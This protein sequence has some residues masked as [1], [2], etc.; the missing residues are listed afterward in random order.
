MKSGQQ[1]KPAALK[2]VNGNPGGRPIQEEV[3][4]PVAEI[5]RPAFVKGK[6][7]RI[8]KQYAPSLEA[9]G[10]LTVWDVDM[11]GAWCCLMAEFQRDPEKFTSAKL[12]Q[13]RLFAECFCLVPPGRARFTPRTN[14]KEDEDSRF[15]G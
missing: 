6:A 7:A 1:P 10:V 12:T 2:L 15:F 11:F 5:K 13:M 3:K 4:P 14:A 9:Q 8:W